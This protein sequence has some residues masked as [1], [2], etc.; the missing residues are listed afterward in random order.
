MGRAE[1]GKLKAESSM[2][3]SMLKLRRAGKS[4]SKGVTSD[5]ILKSRPSAIS[6]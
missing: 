2:F 1:S 4:Q 5:F 6:D 3:P